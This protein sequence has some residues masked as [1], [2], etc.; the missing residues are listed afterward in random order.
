M[1]VRLNPYFFKTLKRNSHFK[2]SNALKKSTNK[3]APGSF[4][5][6]L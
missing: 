3:T 4:K 2:E 6:N 1:V 5:I